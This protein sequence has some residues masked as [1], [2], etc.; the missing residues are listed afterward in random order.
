MFVIEWFL[1]I[2][3]ISKGSSHK[4]LKEAQEQADYILRHYLF[5]YKCQI[6][7]TET[8][9]IYQYPAP[10]GFSTGRK[11]CPYLAGMDQSENNNSK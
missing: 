4:T 3:N 6:R 7:N 9:I 8:N 10:L 1:L 11:K 5:Q 2:G